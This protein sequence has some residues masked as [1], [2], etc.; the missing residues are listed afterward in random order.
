MQT[1]FETMLN[2]KSFFR[3]SDYLSVTHYIHIVS[4]RTENLD[5][6]R[7]DSSRFSN[8]NGRSSQ[9]HRKFSRNL[10]STVLFVRILSSGIDSIH[11]QTAPL[12]KKL[13]K[14]HAALYWAC[15]AMR[16]RIRSLRE[17]SNSPF[18]QAPLS[19]THLLFQHSTT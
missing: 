2:N 16:F 4:P 17:V 13:C 19:C 3:L 7:F 10:E 18:L 15:A 11:T 9:V 1:Y 6:R 5:L 14:P 12:P 8:S